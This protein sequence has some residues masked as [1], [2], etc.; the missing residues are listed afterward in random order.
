VLDPAIGR[1]LAVPET[2]AQIFL[3]LIEND[4]ADFVADAGWKSV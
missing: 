2:Q 4:P 1:P 3:R